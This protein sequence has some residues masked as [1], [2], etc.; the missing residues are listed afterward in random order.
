ML[1]L[2]DLAEDCDRDALLVTVDPLGPTC[3]RETRS[4]FDPEDSPGVAHD[5]G[6]GWLESLWATIVDRAATR[7]EGS[8]TARLLAGGVDATGRR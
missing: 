4:C 8:Y 6:F 7:P 3:H 2:V 1:R 5:R